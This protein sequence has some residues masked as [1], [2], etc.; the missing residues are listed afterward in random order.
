MREIRRRLSWVVFLA[1]LSEAEMVALLRDASFVRLE[2]D[3]EM[4]VGPQKHA[5]WMLLVVAGQLQAFEVSLSSE[6]EFT[7]SVGLATARRWVPLASYPA[8]RAICT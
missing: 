3:Q 2:D 5:E 1:P 8:G 6:R 7:L 4:V